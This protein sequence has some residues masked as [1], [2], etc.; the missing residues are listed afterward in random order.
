MR[1]SPARRVTA[2]LAFG[3]LALGAAACGSS[4]STPTTAASG[5]STSAPTSTSAGA[6]STTPTT[7]AASGSSALAALASK[8]SSGQSATFLAKYNLSGTES[9]HA[10]NGTFEIAHSGTSSLFGFDET[11]GQF[12]E[13]ASGGKSTICAYVGGKWECFTGSE[14]AAFSGAVTSFENVYSSK[15]ELAG[16][17]AEETGAYDVSSSTQTVGGQS[18]SCATFKTH[19]NNGSYTFCI[20]AQGEMAE[21][22]ASTSTGSVTLTLSSYSTSVP[23]STFTPPAA[24]A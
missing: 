4:S 9:G 20:T 8:L 1:N 18:A 10:L 16:L 24:T 14:A 19:T 13:I 11:A 3:A 23:S 2:I 7:T 15:A 22:K 6:T 5:G 21:V 12:E 17:K